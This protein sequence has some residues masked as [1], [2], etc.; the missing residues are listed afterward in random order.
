MVS[1][2][3][4]VVNLSSSPMSQEGML[5]GKAVAA[6]RAFCY[7]NFQSVCIKGLTICYFA[8]C[9]CKAMFLA[10]WRYSDWLKLIIMEYGWWT[11]H[12]ISM[13]ISLSFMWCVEESPVCSVACEQ[14][15]VNTPA[16]QYLWMPIRTSWRKMAAK[17]KGPPLQERIAANF[18]RQNFVEA[19]EYNGRFCCKT[20]KKNSVTATEFPVTL[21][22]FGRHLPFQKS[23]ECSLCLPHSTQLKLSCQ[24][25]AKR[26]KTSAR[27]WGVDELITA[28]LFHVWNR[29]C[30]FWRRAYCRWESSW[31]STGWNVYMQMDGP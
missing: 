4:S 14:D 5:P 2:I 15:T 13:S 25:L 21:S 9:C 8:V 23:T 7:L 3:W 20:S 10:S 31:S 27:A 29:S 17:Y 19:A 1:T 18:K 22:S 11:W 6:V 16:V 24:W 26:L 30:T 12:G 28:R